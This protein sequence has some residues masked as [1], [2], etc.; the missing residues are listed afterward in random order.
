MRPWVTPVLCR[1]TAVRLVDD[2]IGTTA[3]AVRLKG[4]FSLSTL[5]MTL[6]AV[7]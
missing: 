7:L 4:Y 5:E 1:W 6:P 2:Y 3:G